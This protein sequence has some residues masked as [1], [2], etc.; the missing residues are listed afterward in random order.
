ME[1]EQ[2]S[3]AGGQAVIHAH[4]FVRVHFDEHEAFPMLAIAFG[5]R[6]ELFKEILLEFENFFDVH[7]GDKRKGGSNGSVGQEDVLE[8]VVAGGENG[9]ALVHFG[10]VEQVEHGK[11]L[12]GEDAVH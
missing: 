7:A 12:D 2:E 5:F 4:T 11:M 9:S 1:V 10:G 6:L 8:I 3:G